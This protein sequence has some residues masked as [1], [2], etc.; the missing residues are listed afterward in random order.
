MTH[1]DVHS[2]SR[3]LRI[4]TLDKTAARPGVSS[5]KKSVYNLTNEA[6]QNGELSEHDPVAGDWA[7]S[8]AGCQRL[9]QKGRE[10]ISAHTAPSRAETP[11]E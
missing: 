5:G 11:A 2:F 6:A 9:F 3:I 7:D 10:S 8:S 4:S 1:R